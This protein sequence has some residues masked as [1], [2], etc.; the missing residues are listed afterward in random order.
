MLEEVYYGNTL[1]QWLISLIIIIGSFLIAQLILTFNKRVVFKLTKK[2][3]SRLDD[4]LVRTLQSPL[5]FGV[6][7]M[8]MWVALRRLDFGDKVDRYIGEAYKVLTV[9][10]ITWF[11]KC[12]VHALII[13]YLSPNP[14]DASVKSR[15]NFDEH[16]ITLLKKTATAIIWTIG[17]I[18]ALSSIGLKLGAV[19]GALGVG[20]IAFALAA[21]DTIKNI[22][23]GFT[24]LADG[25]FRIGNRIK[26]AGYDGIVEDV[27]IRSTRIR[28]FEK[29]VVIIPNYK[30]VEGALENVSE[31]PM[32]RVKIIL[33][34]V[35]GTSPAKMQRAL[36]ILRQIAVDNPKVDDDSVVASFT[37]FN[38]FA[39][40]ITYIYFIKKGEDV[41]MTQ[42]E[43]N[44]EILTRFNAEGLDFA[45]PTQ[46][47]YMEK[48]D[49]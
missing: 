5:L 31:E 41:L 38:D 45:F 1:E 11:F 21:Q 27:G 26:V 14:D 20:S 42:S 17:A 16:K 7:L 28:T 32:F 39:L 9:V 49:K 37:D 10:N 18:V 34:L 23:G 15:R 48:G 44:V 43:V 36:E 6:I 13:E 47:L 25:T 30:I 33:G 2:S 12:L 46:T 29:R 22:F 40:G 3:K 8:A 35:Y 19:L 24:I 4:I